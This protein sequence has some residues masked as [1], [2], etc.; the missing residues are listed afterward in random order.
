[1]KLGFG[2]RDHIIHLNFNRNKCT[3]IDELEAYTFAR[4]LDKNLTE[5]KD[6]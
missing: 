2:G 4:I 6:I 5:Y 1:M 3:G